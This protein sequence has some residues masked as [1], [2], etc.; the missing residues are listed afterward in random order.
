MKQHFLPIITSLKKV[1]ETQNA[2]L[3]FKKHFERTNIVFTKKYI[4]KLKKCYE[5]ILSSFENCLIVITTYILE[6]NVVHL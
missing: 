3:R 1:S 2:F 5:R 6:Q 4:E